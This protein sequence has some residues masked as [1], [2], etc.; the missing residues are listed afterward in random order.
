MNVI[1][2]YIREPGI[3][4]RS[5]G[6]LLRSIREIST[7]NAAELPVFVRARQFLSKTAV[8]DECGSHS[9]ER[10]LRW[11]RVVGDR[12]V[13]AFDQEDFSG[14]RTAFLCPNDASYVAVQ[15]A[16]WRNGG[17]AVP[18]CP[19]HPTSMIEYVLED[20]QVEMVIS[21]E[22]MVDKLGALGNSVKCL[23][24]PKEDRLAGLE[25]KALDLTTVEENEGCWDDRGAM[26]LYTSGTTGKPKGVLIT[27]RNLR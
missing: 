25:G 10:L 16:I 20:C 21:T 15:W 24:L 26:I 12:L 5:L 11:S 9:Y 13:S 6:T 22:D 18:L 27:H 8:I 2:R 19:V 1:R 23:V 4:P 14:S 17:V 3:R 7:K